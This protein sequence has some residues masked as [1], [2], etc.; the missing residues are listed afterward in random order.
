MGHREVDA[1]V[2]QAVVDRHDD[3]SGP[4]GDLAP[5]DVSLGHLQVAEHERAAVGPHEPAT[6]PLPGPVHT[7]GY[8]AVRTG[9]DGV[10]RL[11]VRSDVAVD[12]GVEARE[13]GHRA[14]VGRPDADRR[15]VGDGR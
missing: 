9:G 15:E 3:G 4:V 13:R 14:G 1:A 5:N 10:D 2:A 12:A 11:D 7:H 6:R 8:V